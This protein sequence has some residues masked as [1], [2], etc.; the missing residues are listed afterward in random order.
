MLCASLYSNSQEFIYNRGLATLSVGVAIPA[1]DFGNESGISLSSYAKTGTTISGEISYFHS[2]NVGFNFMFT[3]SVNSVD[4][5]GL[6]EGYMNESPAF[7]NV[8]AQSEAFRDFAGLGGLVF[9]LP[10]NDYFSFNFKMMAGL[11]N[12]YK[13]TA[14]IETTTVFSE[15]KYYETHD[16]QLIMAFLFSGGTKFKINDIFSVHLNASYMGSHYDFSYYRNSKEVNQKTHIGLLN[17]TCG[18]SYVF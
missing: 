17:I 6:A 10:L 15:V 5:D 1:Y 12:V 4:V 11:R 13:P 8:T 16:N 18:V 9:D 14:L 3:Y 2:W 7:E